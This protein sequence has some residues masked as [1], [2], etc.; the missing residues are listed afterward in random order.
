MKED[1]KQREKFRFDFL[2]KVCELSNGDTNVSVNPGIA[3]QAAGI[4]DASLL[5]I[6]ISCLEKEHLLETVKQHWG[7]P[8]VHLT[9]QGLEEVR[10]TVFQPH[11]GGMER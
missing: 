6:T 5:R 7:P 8:S 9:Q 1:Q 10:I 3:A 11:H 2:K 4:N